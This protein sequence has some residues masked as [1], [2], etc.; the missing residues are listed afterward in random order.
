[1]VQDEID[2]GP[3]G[4]GGE[5]FEEFQGLEEQVARAIVPLALEL[6]PDAAVAGEPEA[7]L[8]DRRPEQV[9]VEIE[10]LVS[11]ALEEG[12]AL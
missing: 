6:Q 7:V 12:V 4:Q 2:A 1:M 9:G 10:A 8:G 3:R 5:C 11:L